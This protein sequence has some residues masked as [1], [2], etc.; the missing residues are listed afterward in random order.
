MKNMYFFML[1]VFVTGLAAC[2]KTQSNSNLNV[3]ADYW[4]GQLNKALEPRQAPVGL[5]LAGVT[6]PEE[7]AFGAGKQKSTLEAMK[8]QGTKVPMDFFDLAAMNL[9]KELVDLPA[10]AE[11]YVLDVDGTLTDK[12]FTRFSFQG[13]A[14]APAADSDSQKK[15]KELAD[16]FKLNLSTPNDRQQLRRRLMQMISPKGKTVLEEITAKYQAKFNR[17][18]RITSLVRSIDYSID[19]NK[20]DAGSFLVKEN[21]DLP[22]H[23]SGLAFDIAIK[24]LTAEEQNFLVGLLAEMDKNGRVDAVRE[25]G[26]TGVFH[27][28][29]L[30]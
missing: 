28:F 5:D 16:S 20:V 3:T 25:T 17:P 15:M 6:I 21:G 22:P 4:Q 30:A 18:L 1:L 2:S 10:A 24:N 9:N 14:A 12:E 19:L 11:N 8:A 7:L 26:P 13:G 23:C 27:V 29:V